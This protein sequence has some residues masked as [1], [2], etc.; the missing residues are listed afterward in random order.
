VTQERKDVRERA[1][2]EEMSKRARNAK[3]ARVLF[4][5]MMKKVRRR[6]RVGWVMSWSRM[7]GMSH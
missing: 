2:R 1:G 4:G 3:A 7:V 6:R 5:L